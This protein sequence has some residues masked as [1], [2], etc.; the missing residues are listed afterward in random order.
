MNSSVVRQKG[1]SQNGGNKKTKHIL[2]GKKCLFSEKIG[3]LCF[4]VT[5]VLRFALLLYYRRVYVNLDALL[6]IFVGDEIN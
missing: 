2:G 6:E 5:S 1:E 3:K 4:L